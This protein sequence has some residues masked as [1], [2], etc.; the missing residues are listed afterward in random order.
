MTASVRAI[1]HFELHSIGVEDAEIFVRTRGSG[2]PLLMLHGYP[3]THVCWARIAPQLSE[4]FTVVLADLTGYGESKGPQPQ[5]DGGNYSKRVVAAQ[6]IAMMEALGH[7]RFNLAGH[8][9]GARVSYR[10]ALD[11]PES[12]ERLA[13]LSILPT[14][15]MWKRLGDVK[16]AIQTYHW[17]L[18]AQKPPIPHDL[19]AGAPAKQVRNTIA[20]WTKSQTLDAFTSEELAAYS[21]AL[22]RRE[23][24]AAICAEYR[25]G[26]TTDRKHDEA[27]LATQRKIECP[28]LLLWGVDEYPEDEML[29]AWREIASNVRTHPIDCGHFV[30]EEAPQETL[31]ALLDFFQS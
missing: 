11:H 10:L 15:A 17:F 28:T 25:A 16:R 8:D 27:N 3:Q 29:A 5:E 24:I 21:S 1:E 31:E 4:R 26:W 20:S 19:L 30:T 7:K 23:V 9:R 12:V 18:L 14:F 2:P 13:V 6:M 22:S